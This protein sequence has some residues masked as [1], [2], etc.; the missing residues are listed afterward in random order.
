MS[1]GAGRGMNAANTS[2][3]KVSSCH[4]E[5]IDADRH[6]AGGRMQAVRPANVYHSPGN[7]QRMEREE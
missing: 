6:S 1:L 5:E 3:D 2:R 4:K 7:L